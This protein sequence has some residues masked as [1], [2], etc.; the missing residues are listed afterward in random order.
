[1]MRSLIAALALVSMASLV[2]TAKGDAAETR[3]QH[4][5]VMQMNQNDPELMNLLLNNASNVIEHFR[6]RNED[7]ELE[8]VAYGPGLHMLREDTSPVKERIRRLAED[9]FPAKVIFSACNITKQGMEKREGR[10]IT[11]VPQ[12]TLV[13]SGVV[14]IME[15][16]EQGWSYVRP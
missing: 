14:Q 3:K 8:I 12:A 5:V 1:M 13:P 2:W 16:Q 10:A 6:G 7:V 9:T 11:I 15:L 4:R